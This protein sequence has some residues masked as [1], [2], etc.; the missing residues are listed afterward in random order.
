M[1]DGIVNLAYL[2]AAVMFILGLVDLSH[3]RTA[4]RGNR[5]AAFG[6]LVAVAATVVHR[7]M[8]GGGLQAWV[9]VAAAMVLG[10]VI[11]AALA[12]RVAMTAMP[13]MVALLNGFG[14]G[15]SLLVAGAALTD[16]AEAGLQFTLA[17]V[18]SA[19]IGGV[20]FWGS[21]VAFDKL[22]EL[23]LPARPIHF[24]RQHAVTF[25]TAA[26]VVALGAW[27][28]VQPGA[29]AAYWA[30]VAAA[31]VLGILLTIPIGGADMPVAVALLNA[32][33]GLAAAATGFV[34]DNNVLI[35]SGSLVGASGIILT[36][37]MCRAMNRS[38]TAVLTG[39]IGDGQGA[40][41]SGLSDAA[42]KSATAE[43]VAMLLEDAGRVVIVPG[44][45]MAVAQAQHAVRDLARLLEAGG[46]VVEFAIHPV[47]GR[48]PG[49]MNVLLAEADVPY[50]QLKEMDEA[51]AVMGQTDV[52]IVIGA[53]D[54]VNPLA[55][56]DPSSPIAGMPIIEAEKAKTVVVVKRGL[57]VGFAGIANPLFT[58]DNTLM[59]FA[60]ARKGIMEIT[61]ALKEAQPERA[62]AVPV[63]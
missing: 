10:G 25:G 57:G 30:L 19:A 7:E 17:T 28:A 62:A 32:Y 15:A 40:A 59:Y 46:T 48:M 11:G 34:L 56:R 8:L 31:S 44:Y 53:N 36:R 63:T 6:M 27:V 21:L 5:V 22:Q 2:V 35:I 3:P 18:A 54:V 51:N 49:H 4:V 38:L 55:R 52:A 58:A 20:T 24:A 14:G 50:E 9:L 41:A 47:A 13:Q 16:T 39:S 42:A 60:D 45:G 33:S 1:S 29:L 43:E 61:S 23:V 12:L 37:V 26:L